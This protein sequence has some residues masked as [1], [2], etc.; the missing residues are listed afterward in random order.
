MHSVT[1][2]FP[3]LELLVDYAV[4]VRADSF[5]FST[6]EI[7][8]HAHILSCNSNE[9]NRIFFKTI[10]RVEAAALLAFPLKTVVHLQIKIKRGNVIITCA[11]IF[12][13]VRKN[14]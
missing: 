2:K 9:I 13:P 11:E 6:P 10:K 7:N 12:I 4:S 3:Q 1:P 14:K 8:F 5:L